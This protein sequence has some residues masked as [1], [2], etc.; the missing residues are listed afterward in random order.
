LIHF[1]KRAILKIEVK[2]AELDS[3][4]LVCLCVSL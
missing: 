3:K 4:Y 2:T 1:Y